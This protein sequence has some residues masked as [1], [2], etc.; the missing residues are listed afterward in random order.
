V[1]EA[2]TET[3]YRA[4]YKSQVR[5]KVLRYNNYVKTLMP[6]IVNATVVCLF[7]FGCQMQLPWAEQQQCSTYSGEERDTCYERQAEAEGNAELCAHVEDF[8]VRERCYLRVALIT[9]EPELCTYLRLLYSAEGCVQEIA[10]R[11]QCRGV[12]QE[13]FDAT[14]TCEALT[15]NKQDRCYSEAALEAQDAFLCEKITGSQ[16]AEVEGNLPR[17]Q[18]Y[19]SL[20]VALCNPRICESIEGGEESFTEVQCKQLISRECP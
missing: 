14:D 13:G 8:E 18:C 19:L 16:F 4:E 3:F 2:S 5:Q 9:C 10:L 6:R 15:G 1:E 12:V 20:A 17:D 7:L 11:E